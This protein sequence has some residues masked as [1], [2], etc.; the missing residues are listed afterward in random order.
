MRTVYG[1]EVPLSSGIFASLHGFFLS[2][3]KS[4]PKTDLILPAKRLRLSAA[5]PILM[6]IEKFD[7]DLGAL[8]A[9]T[10]SKLQNAKL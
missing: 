4:A 8:L 7:Y 2:N 1:Q 6:P 3:R 5:T 10:P 9:C